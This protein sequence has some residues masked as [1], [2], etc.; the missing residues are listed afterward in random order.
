MDKINYKDFNHYEREQ[1]FSAWT[2]LIKINLLEKIL[3]ID[4]IE[5]LKNSL[6][7]EFDLKIY[8]SEKKENIETE[9]NW[10]ITIY[11][12]EFILI[13]EIWTDLYSLDFNNIIDSHLWIKISDDFLWKWFW[14]ILYKLYEKWSKINKNIFYPFE[15]F[16]IKNSRITLLLKMWYKLDSR[17]ENWEFKKLSNIE[18]DVF[19]AW[20]RK[21][22][23]WEQINI[24]KLILDE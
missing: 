23:Y 10:C 8:F 4:E 22:Y 15:D 18:K 17:Y 20:V 19:L 16:A 3:R 7:K 12:K 21:N 13:W 11:S 6:E 2:K 24:Y 1:N 9:N 14:I 5:V